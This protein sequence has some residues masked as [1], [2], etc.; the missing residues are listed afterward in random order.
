MADIA[1]N[2]RNGT[3][4]NIHNKS[5]I[6]YNENAYVVAILGAIG[7]TA[8]AAQV[9]DT[10][11]SPITSVAGEY[12]VTADDTATGFI[13]KYSNGAQSLVPTP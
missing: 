11:I 2:F 5:D 6:N 10:P 8:T 3:S 4:S 9:G 12:D 1:F 7:S 13:F